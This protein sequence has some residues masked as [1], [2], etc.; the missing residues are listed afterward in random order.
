MNWGEVNPVHAYYNGSCTSKDNEDPSWSTSF[1]TRRTSK[2]SSALEA[3]WKTLFMLYLYKIGTLFCSSSGSQ[4]R[5]GYCCYCWFG[6]CKWVRETDKG[7]LYRKPT[8]KNHASNDLVLKGTLA[9]GLVGKIKNID[10][11]ILGKDGKPMTRRCVRFSDA[12]KED[13]SG[14]VQGKNDS[15]REVINPPEADILVPCPLN[16]RDQAIGLSSLSPMKPQ[17]CNSVAIPKDA[18]DEIGGRFVN[19]LYGYS[20]GKRLAYPLVENYVKHVWAKYGLTRIMMHQGFFLFQFESK[21]SMEQVM[22]DGPWR[23]K[24]VP[25]MLK[26]WKT[27]KPMKKDSASVLPL[28]IKMHNVPIVAYSHVGLNLITSKVRRLICYDSHTNNICLNSWGRISYARALVEV[29]AD[30]PLVDSVVATIP[31]DIEEE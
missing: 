8:V 21:K 2:T 4:L 6:I 22:L 23:I 15:N 24:L 31:L 3:L 10:G 17:A 18:V 29:S 30:S 25:I 11:K 5:A 27:N 13:V 19:T 1:K 20:V 26:V 9:S 7:F 28:W 14:V 16:D 12:P